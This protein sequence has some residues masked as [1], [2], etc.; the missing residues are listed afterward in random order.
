MGPSP[1]SGEHDDVD[2]PFVRGSFADGVYTLTLD[3]P[4]NRNALSARLLAEAHHHLDLALEPALGARALV[5]D[6]TGPAFCAGADLSERSDRP[7]DSGPFVRLLE[8]LMDS[9]CPS[10]A[11]VRGPARAGGIGLLA[12]CDLAVV[13]STV[14][15]A[16]TEVRIGVTA[17]IISVPILRRVRPSSI[18]AALLTGQTFDATEARRIGLITHVSDDV[19]HTLAELTSG[20]RAGAPAAVAAT[21]VILSSVPTLDRDTAFEEMRALSERFFASSDA[22]EGMAAFREKRPPSW[23]EGRP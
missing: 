11:V 17:A 19:D 12:S 5:V 18:A 23:S 6:H 7:I 10:I 9:P 16:L 15:F 4:H 14:T 21:K 1:T 13:A 20:I 3:S 2:R 22:R 8:R